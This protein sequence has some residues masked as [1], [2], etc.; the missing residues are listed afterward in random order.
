MLTCVRLNLHAV[1]QL[2]VDLTVGVVERLAAAQCRRFV[3]FVQRLGDDLVVVTLAL[4]PI[5][6][7]RLLDVAVVGAV[8]PVAEVGVAERI[9][10]ELNNT[11]LRED[12]PLTD[13]AHGFALPGP[14]IATVAFPLSVSRYF[15]NRLLGLSGMVSVT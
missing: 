11:S 13:G 9:L 5:G 1:A 12:F 10:E 8:L 15:C 7:Q 6:E 3:Q 14:N 4:Q 2:T